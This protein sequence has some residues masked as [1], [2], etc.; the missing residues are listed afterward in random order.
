MI[1]KKCDYTKWTNANAIIHMKVELKL[2][3]KGINTRTLNW[4]P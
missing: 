2:F 1:K 3:V 4:F